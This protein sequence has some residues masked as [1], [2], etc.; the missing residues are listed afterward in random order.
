MQVQ[1]SGITP[2]LEEGNMNKKSPPEVGCKEL[3]QGLFSYVELC[4]K[5]KPLPNSVLVTSAGSKRAR[6]YGFSNASKLFWRS[7]RSIPT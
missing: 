5:R 4:Y 6:R 1:T 2:L 3:E 7:S